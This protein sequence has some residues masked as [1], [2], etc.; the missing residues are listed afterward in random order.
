MGRQAPAE[1]GG[2]GLAFLAV[3]EEEERGAAFGGSHAQ[4]PTGGE[5]EGFGVPADIGD[6]AGDR[7]AGEGF[8]GNPKKIAHRRGADDD[9]LVGIK[10]EGQQ[11]RP[12]GEAEKLRVADKL[13]INHREALG[14][15]KAS[16]LSQGKAETGPAIAHGI[17]KNLLREPAGKARKLSIVG[18]KSAL[19]HLRQCRLALDIGNGVA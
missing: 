4:A 3:A 18:A 14:G 17:G 5:I 8:F 15:E 16:G 7:P 19:A 2:T 13:E 9:Q 11:A 1:V 10:A 12:I 6:D